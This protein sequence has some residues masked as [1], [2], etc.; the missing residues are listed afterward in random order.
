[1]FDQDAYNAMHDR[2]R[3][4]YADYLAV[5]SAEAKKQDVCGPH[6]DAYVLHSPGTCQY[7]DAFP[8]LQDFRKGRYIA[9]TDEPPQPNKRPCPATL[10]R[11]AETIHR[12]HGN[13]PHQG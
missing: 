13:R 7:C 2:V 8:V 12:W 5:L 4:D 3:R 1:M 9:F 6:C 10:L 11:S